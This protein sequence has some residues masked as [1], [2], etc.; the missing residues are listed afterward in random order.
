MAAAASRRSSHSG[1]L[2]AWRSRF[3]RTNH[4]A[5]SCQCARFSSATKG[6]AFSA[7]P[8]MKVS[9]L[10][11]FRDVHH[12]QRLVLAA[13]EAAK[14]H[15][16]RRV[17]AGNYLR[18]RLLMVS[19]AVPAHEARDCLLIHGKRAAETATLVGPGELDQFYAP[20][21]AEKES[22]FVEGLHHH[23]RGASEP[24]LSQAV[25][26]HMQSH[27]AGEVTV[28]LDYPGDVHQVFAELERRRAE[29]IEVCP[30]LQPLCVVVAHHRYTASRGRDHMIIL[31]EDLEK[32]L[33]KR[34]RV[35]RATRV[36]HGLAAA[37]LLL[38]KVDIEAEAA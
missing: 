13:D 22:Y 32:S 14:V 8:I 3:S 7:C 1:I 20:Q 23:F 19:D 9:R 34:P 4:R 11:D 10:P 12:P 29:V 26:A 31:A 33:G 16:A 2:S 36:S 30:P 25:T 24:Q 21:L 5:W 6:A 18:P 35:F 38:G 37:C 28:N 17:K 15:K 27:L